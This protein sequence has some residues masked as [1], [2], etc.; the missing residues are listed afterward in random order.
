MI[1]RF[2]TL[3]LFAVTANAH[4]GP[5]DNKSCDIVYKTCV[6]SASRNVN[7]EM[8]TLRQLEPSAPDNCWEYQNVYRCVDDNWSEPAACANISSRGYH[9]VAQDI[10]Q[11]FFQ[12]YYPGTNTSQKLSSKQNTVSTKTTDIWIQSKSNPYKLTCPSDS[13][14]N[15]LAS[16]A[17]ISSFNTG[18]EAANCT[19]SSGWD[20]VGGSTINA[21]YAGVPY[22]F[23]HTDSSGNVFPVKQTSHWVCASERMSSCSITDIEDCDF[24]GVQTSGSP[25]PNIPHDS[26]LAQYESG[27]AT[28]ACPLITNTTCDSTIESCENPFQSTRINHPLYGHYQLGTEEKYLCY[29]GATTPDCDRP[30]GYATCQ[31]SYYDCNELDYD[32]VPAENV[33]D[34]RNYGYCKNWTDQY[35]CPAEVVVTCDD[36]KN[37]CGEARLVSESHDRGGKLEQWIDEYFC[38]N[39]DINESCDDPNNNQYHGCTKIGATCLRRDPDNLTDLDPIYGDCVEWV[40]DYACPSDATYTCDGD[41]T[42]CRTPIVRSGSSETSGDY[43]GSD[44]IYFDSFETDR[45][46]DY[47][48]W[49]GDVDTVCSITDDID[50]SQCDWTGYRC[51]ESDPAKEQP[52][53][54]EGRD[55]GTCVDWTDNWVCSNSVE[56]TCDDDTLVECGPPDRSTG[57][58][59]EVSQCVL[60]NLEA[61]RRYNE[62]IYN[63]SSVAICSAQFAQQV[64]NDTEGDYDETNPDGEDIAWTESF[65]CYTGDYVESCDVDPEVTDVKECQLTGF[66]CFQEDPIVTPDPYYGQCVSWADRY[67]CGH[68]EYTVCSSEFEMCH[69]KTVE[70]TEENA[71]GVQTLEREVEFCYTDQIN[72][73][74]CVLD[75]D[76]CYLYHTENQCDAAMAS[77]QENYNL[78]MDS[79]NDAAYCSTEFPEPECRTEVECPTGDRFG[80]D[81]QLDWDN[82]FASIDTCVADLD[83]SMEY[84]KT[85]A[86]LPTC[87]PEE[88]MYVDCPHS[89]FTCNSWDYDISAEEAAANNYEGR[90][91]GY[92]VDWQDRY[93]C[94]QHQTEDCTADIDKTECGPLGYATVSEVIDGIATDYVTQIECV[95]GLAEECVMNDSCELVGVE[96]AESR[97]GVC[98]REQQIWNCVENRTDCVEFERSCAEPSGI[99]FGRTNEKPN[100]IGEMLAKASVAKMIAENSSFD[101]GEIRIFAGIEQSCRDMDDFNVSA[102]ITVALATYAYTYESSLLDI[103]LTWIA[104]LAIDYECCVIDNT[105]QQQEK[106]A[107]SGEICDPATDDDCSGYQPGILEMAICSDEERELSK[108]RAAKHVIGPLDEQCSIDLLGICVENE[109][110]FCEFDNLFSRIVQEQGRQQIA[111]ALLRGPVGSEV[112]TINF[113]YFNVVDGGGWELHEVNG[114]KIAFW[115]WD[116]R[117]NNYLLDFNPSDDV[118]TNFV[119][120]CPYSDEV[121]IAACEGDQCFSL[122]NSPYTTASGAGQTDYKVTIVDPYISSGVAVTSVMYVQGQCG[123]SVP[124]V[125]LDVV[126]FTKDYLNIG[127]ELSLSVPKAIINSGN[128]LADIREVLVRWG[129]GTTTTMALDDAG[130]YYE[131]SKSYAFG[132]GVDGNM[133]EV[134]LYDNNGRT[135]RTFINVLVDDGLTSNPNSLAQAGYVDFSGVGVNL[136][137]DDCEYKVNAYPGGSG[138]STTIGYDISWVTNGVQ[139]KWSEFEFYAGQV[140]I[141]PFEQGSPD[142][143]AGVTNVQVKIDDVVYDVPKDT[144]GVEV[145]VGGLLFLGSCNEQFFT[146]NYRV[147]KEV[148]LDLLPWGAGGELNCRG[149][150]VDE[151]EMLDF[152]AMDLSEWIATILP[153]APTE[154][155][156][157]EIVDETLQDKKDALKSGVVESGGEAKVVY[158]T[159]LIGHPRDT[160]SFSVVPKVIVGSYAELEF[161]KVVVNWGDG[162]DPEEMTSLAGQGFKASKVYNRESGRAGFDVTFAL[163]STT[164]EIYETSV[165]II[166]GMGVGTESVTKEIGGGVIEINKYKVNGSFNSNLYDA[167]QGGG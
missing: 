16:S 17:S 91:Y 24:I 148:V 129:D 74:L 64:C 134:I 123:E 78:C 165:H 108:A 53:T 127:E 138:A 10:T 164:G 152:G 158:Y 142:G 139:P 153:V 30:Q 112:E 117:C 2:L 102:L 43:S 125:N 11:T 35:V 51:H 86:P 12:S 156:V 167:T 13:S 159:Q 160:M 113:P 150:S 96:C 121:H 62:C 98:L 124:V 136:A 141:V 32:I 93:V 26:V 126:D 70:H 140:R 116:P 107:A 71:D 88:S 21:T 133:V 63:G 73:S 22:S 155:E 27:T 54:F 166:I 80:V 84:C 161:F 44:E 18:A 162:S 130:G 120:L 104:L 1:R 38:Y 25:N 33:H 8:K 110:F 20:A 15:S 31:W 146:C 118:D 135:Y 41:I 36:V 19:R 144:N 115:H 143:T 65:I 50:T 61:E 76:K 66:T 157:V 4:A 3:V 6:D 23:T 100:N 37:N 97:N 57:G 145:P 83:N 49:T 111:D 40:D 9:V 101:A 34:G 90:N 45:I 55:Y 47:Y 67:V 99:D 75:Q 132:S 81:C 151:V 46:D 105:E 68:E 7:G 154:D 137:Y 56:V 82:Y 147:Y 58:S 109:Q 59:V 87:T 103:A 60:D 163:Y 5:Y 79:H 128:A 122:P 106:A 119:P 14:L 72:D 48:C 85:Q 52:N 95:A 42:D 77:R 39:G 149:L 89:G 131:A 69:T 114:N 29:D 92:C 94:P 28:Y